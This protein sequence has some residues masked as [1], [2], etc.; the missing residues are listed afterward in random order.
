TFC[1]NQEFG[2]LSKQ[3]DWY[4]DH[5]KQ[6]KEEIQSLKESF[7]QASEKLQ[8][9]EKLL[10]R[11]PISRNDENIPT[12]YLITPTHTRLEQKAELTRLSHTL[13]HVKNLHWIVIEDCDKKTNLVTNFLANCGVTYTHLYAETPA[14]V[15]LKS[16]DPNWLKPRGV[17]Q[18]NAGLTWLRKNLNPES[19]KGVVYFADDDNTYD[20]DLFEEMR[21]TKK[22]SVWP[23]GLVGALRYEKRPFAMDMA[24]FAVNLKLIHDHPEALFSNTVPRGY[25]ESTILKKMS[26]T[27]EDLEPKANNCKKILV[28][29]TRTE[30]TKTKNE[31]KMKKKIGSGSDPNMEV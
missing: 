25:Q 13:R 18:R 15:K 4:K 21:Y 23:V 3:I 2:S 14:Q 12:I 16:N 24:G 8:R 6:Q 30:K 28:W 9:C 11:K 1:G 27:L 19:D 22:V 20:L 7:E 26:L 17:L 10:R 31:D 29:H 5:I